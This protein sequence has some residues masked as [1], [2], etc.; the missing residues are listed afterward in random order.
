[1]LQGSGL[2]ILSVDEQAIKASEELE[3]AKFKSVQVGLLKEQQAWQD[4]Q[5]SV[6]NFEQLHKTGS[7]C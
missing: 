4:Y 5:A 6:Q 7:I 2:Q 1:M 3:V